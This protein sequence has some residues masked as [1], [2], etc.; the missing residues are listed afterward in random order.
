MTQ[1]DLTSEEIQIIGTLVDKKK[2]STDWVLNKGIAQNAEPL[3]NKVV[4]YQS[5]L[6]KI[7]FTPKPKQETF[8]EY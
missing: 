8:D 5:I 2:S 4:L 1:V 3:K 7:N 6:K